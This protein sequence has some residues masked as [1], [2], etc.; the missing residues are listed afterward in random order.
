VGLHTLSAWAVVNT[1]SL[2]HER[3]AGDFF[4]AGRGTVIAKAAERS[5][6]ITTMA[7]RWPFP[8]ELERTRHVYDAAISWASSVGEEPLN[9]AVALSNRGALLLDIGEVDAA[10]ADLRAAVYLAPGD[11][12]ALARKERAI[13]AGG[14]WSP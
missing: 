2:S 13:A 1:V 10:V 8:G 4:H 14:K 6:C 12:H 9:L 11:I 5:H 7:T 3:S